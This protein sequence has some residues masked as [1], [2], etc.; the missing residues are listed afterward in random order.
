M[1]FWGLGFRD[2]RVQNLGFRVFVGKD[3]CEMAEQ[4]VGFGESE[5]EA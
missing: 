5:S 4:C 3:S 1:G 2:Y